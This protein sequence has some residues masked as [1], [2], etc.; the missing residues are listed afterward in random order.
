M[1]YIFKS[2]LLAFV[3]FP[4]VVIFTAHLVITTT[5]SAK[6]SVI[7]ISL[8]SI[9]LFTSFSLVRF[10]ARK[11]DLPDCFALRYWP[12]MAPMEIILVVR[13]LLNA[14]VKTAPSFHTDALFAATAL[15]YVVLIFAFA[16]CVPPEKK[17]AST[18]WRWQTCAYIA[19]LFAILAWQ[20]KQD[21]NNTLRG[22]FHGTTVSDEPIVSWYWPWE[23]RNRLP[24]LDTPALL[25]ISDDCPRI[26]G[27]TS[28]VPIYSAVVN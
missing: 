9:L 12:L 14:F 27:A 20:A 10:H 11:S 25:L 3:F 4:V 16:V 15:C 19:V 26:N 22:S 24:K 7:W 2:F 5:P 18:R 17:L 28:F 8:L 23:E 13:I 21:F 6:D 1:K